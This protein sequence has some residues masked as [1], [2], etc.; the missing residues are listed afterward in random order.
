MIEQKVVITSEAKEI[1]DTIANGWIVK[2]VTAQHVSISHGGMH[3]G[4][5]DKP[6]IRGYFCF[7]LEKGV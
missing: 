4:T 1:N 3:I 6:A 7:V 5:I 2:S